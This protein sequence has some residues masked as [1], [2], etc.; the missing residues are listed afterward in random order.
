MQKDFIDGQQTCEAGFLPRAGLGSDLGHLATN[1]G[2]YGPSP[3]SKVV[4]EALIQRFK[5]TKN[6]TTN[7][8][9]GQRGE[10]KMRES[11]PERGRVS[12][13]GIWADR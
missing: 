5:L 3:W 4:A 11:G 8:G 13:D 7:F 1:Q 12:T 2:E 9:K 6:K 10:R